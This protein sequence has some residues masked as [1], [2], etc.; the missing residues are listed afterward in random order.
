MTLNA[1]LAF[2][3]KRKFILDGAE[4]VDGCLVTLNGPFLV[5]S[6]KSLMGRSMWTDDS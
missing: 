2:F 4:H 1:G 5:K 3:A 6:E